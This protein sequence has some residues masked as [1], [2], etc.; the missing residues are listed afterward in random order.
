MGNRE[1]KDVQQN[2]YDLQ[3]QRNLDNFSEKIIFVIGDSTI[4]DENTHSK[5]YF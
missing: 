5:C 2:G 1:I 4:Q 3:K